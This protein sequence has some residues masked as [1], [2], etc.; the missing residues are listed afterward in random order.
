MSDDYTSAELDSIW[1]RANLDFPTIKEVDDFIDK[2]A[3][4]MNVMGLT[5]SEARAE[6]LAEIQHSR[7]EVFP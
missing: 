7:D 3:E 4:L 1:L 6:A 5:E 2:V